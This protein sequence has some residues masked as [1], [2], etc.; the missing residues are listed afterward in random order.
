MDDE[1]IAEMIQEAE[2]AG[3]PG[4]VQRVVHRGD[5]EVPAAIAQASLQSAGWVYIYDRKSGEQSVINRN[6][7]P[8]ALQKQW[9]DGTPVFTTRKPTIGPVRGTLKCML[10]A[11]DPDRK[12]Y[13]ELGFTTCKKSNLRSPY[14]VRRH[15]QKRHKAEWAAI[16]EEREER[17]RQEDRDFQRELLGRAKP[18]IGTPEAPLYVSDKPK[19]GRPKKS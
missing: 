9:P 19:V 16:Q 12:H 5:D 17:K 15:M 3:E 10:H 2:K 8:R 6:M 4:G 7:L 11:D 13:D 1:Q 18:V 14:E